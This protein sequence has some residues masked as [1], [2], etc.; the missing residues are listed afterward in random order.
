MGA[1]PLI[2]YNY[3]AGNI[4]K[5]S[6]VIKRIIILNVSVGA[7]TTAAVIGLRSAVIGLFL[8]DPAV[9]AM[10]ENILT[11]IMISSPFLG[12]FF[13]GTNFLQATGDAMKATLMSV[14]QKGLLLIPALFVSEYLYGFMGIRIAYVIADFGSVIIACIFL[15][16]G[17]KKIS[18]R[19]RS[20]AQGS[21]QELAVELKMP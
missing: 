1:Q 15:I 5:L 18:E 16:T 2:S 12:F 11:I 13:L 9:A 4:K 6:G 10:A 20:T 3:G 8:K 21:D 14:L 7:V 19:V 17:W